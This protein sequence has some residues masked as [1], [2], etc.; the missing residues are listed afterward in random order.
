MT[1][2]GSAEDWLARIFDAHARD[3]H[4]Y[5]RRRLQGASDPIADADDLTAEVFAITW[6]RRDD[7]AD[8]ALA[9]LY[10]VARRVLAAHRRRVVTLPVLEPADT[11]E[12]A[13]ESPADDVADLV[14]DD[15]ALRAAW[16]TLADRDREVL[17][18]AAWEGLTETQIATVLGVSVGGASSAL[19]RARARLRDALTHQNQADQDQADL[20]Q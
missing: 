10:G 3:V 16:A 11:D 14:T 7:V 9:W 19:S 2:D 4:R 6:R 13:D 12:I 18:L 8:P 5:L 1:D 20:D 15:L 17:L